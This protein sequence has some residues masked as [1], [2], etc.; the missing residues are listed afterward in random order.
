VKKGDMVMFTDEGSY[1]KWF[2]GQLG[3]V[4][5]H[6]VHPTT[7][8]ESCRVEW[9]QPVLYHGRYTSVSDFSADMFEVV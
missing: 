1:G 8:R 5:R 9:L 7:R 6:T 3:I 4:M 2:F